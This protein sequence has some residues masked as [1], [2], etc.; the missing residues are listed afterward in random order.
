[1]TS[2]APLRFNK[3]LDTKA[4][5]KR[6]TASIHGL[7]R[8]RFDMDD[9][10]NPESKLN[11][12][13]NGLRKQEG[14]YL[15]PENDNLGTPHGCHITFFDEQKNRVLIAVFEPGEMSASLF[16]LVTGNSGYVPAQGHPYIK[17]IFERLMNSL[18]HSGWI[19]P[20]MSSY[21]AG[22]IESRGVVLCYWSP[23]R[24]EYYTE[25]EDPKKKNQK[26]KKKKLNPQFLSLKDILAEQD[27]RDDDVVFKKPL[28]AVLLVFSQSSGEIHHFAA[29]FPANVISEALATML[30]TLNGCSVSE[31]VIQRGNE[32]TSM[33]EQHSHFLHFMEAFHQK[34]PCLL[35]ANPSWETKNVTAD[36][37]RVSRVTSIMQL[38]VE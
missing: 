11:L 36:V 10:T 18:Y 31:R 20:T 19:A 38:A 34:F 7:L 32:S 13:T 5:I 8:F 29:H 9:I 30:L 24:A 25:K 23:Q 35:E 12:A 33:D 15:S 3:A 2:I 1:M 6:L 4:L 22:L 21:H 17:M 27:P 28:S 26:K 16:E 14:M 37:L